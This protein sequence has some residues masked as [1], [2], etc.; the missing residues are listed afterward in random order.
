M[1]TQQHVKVASEAVAAGTIGGATLIG[2]LPAIAG[3]LA[4]LAAFAW[5]ILQMYWG[6]ID[7]HQ[8]NRQD[9]RK[10]MV[11]YLKDRDNKE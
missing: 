2:W 1:I 9:D 11:D 3:T 5:V 4:S 10:S 6:I 7:R 8:K